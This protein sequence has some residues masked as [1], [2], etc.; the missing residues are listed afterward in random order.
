MTDYFETKSP[1]IRVELVHPAK[2][3]HYLICSTVYPVGK[4][5]YGM[6]LEMLMEPLGIFAISSFGSKA[7]ID[8]LLCCCGS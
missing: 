5:T 6:K 4:I 7:F 3:L 1:P 2:I 8:F